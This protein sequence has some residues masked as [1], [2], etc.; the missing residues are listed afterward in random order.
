M[1]ESAT[2]HAE[3]LRAIAMACLTRSAWEGAVP[4]PET[5]RGVGLVL[6]PAGSAPKAGSTWIK[7]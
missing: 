4:Y 1:T 5:M 7:L 3:P 6:R 2:M